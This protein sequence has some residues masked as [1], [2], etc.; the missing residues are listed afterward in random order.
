MVF[1]VALFNF[2]GGLALGWLYW[3]YGLLSAFLAH[4]LAGLLSI[5]VRAL[6]G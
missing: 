5:T 3:R 4:L 6:S 2:L 1:N